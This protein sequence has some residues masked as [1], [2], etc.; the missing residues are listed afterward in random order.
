MRVLKG[1]DGLMQVPSASAM[2]VGN[3]DGVHLGHQRLLDTCRQ[4][5]NA[6]AMAV[7]VVTFEPHPLTVLR[8]AAAPPRLVSPHR[9]ETLIEKHGADY[10]VVLAPEPPVLNLAA[11]DFWKILRDD[12]K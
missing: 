7:A 5:R 1:I 2:T 9:K 12:V 6:G 3:F 11:E 4:R 10:Y 8:P